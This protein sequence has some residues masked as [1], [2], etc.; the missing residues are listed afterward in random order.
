VKAVLVC[1]AL[2]VVARHPAVTI[3]LTAGLGAVVAGQVLYIIR[4]TLKP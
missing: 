1:A 2:A 3:T 4:R